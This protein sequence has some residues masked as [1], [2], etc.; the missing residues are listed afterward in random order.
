MSFWS[1]FNHHPL[2]LIFLLHNTPAPYPSPPPH[3]PPP[4]HPHTHMHPPSPVEPQPPVSTYQQQH[5]RNLKSV[6]DNTTQHNTAQHS[7]TPPHHTTQHHTTQHSTTQ[8]NT[9]HHTTQH[10]TTPHHTTQHHT[11]QHSTTQHSTTQH[12]TQHRT[13][14]HNTAQR[15]TAQHNTTQRNATQHSISGRRGWPSKTAILRPRNCT[16]LDPAARTATEQVVKR[17]VSPVGTTPER[18]QLRAKRHSVKDHQL[19]LAY[20]CLQ[21]FSTRLVWDALHTIRLQ[22]YY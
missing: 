16:I 8:H 9:A 6:T 20:K 10:H 22:N 18:A 7:T 14:T 3:P 5:R 15:N 13:T 1:I 11:T 21:R 4:N 19:G 17:P 12:T 2:P